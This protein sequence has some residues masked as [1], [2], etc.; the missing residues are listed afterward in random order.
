MA[1]NKS[2][3]ELM[4]LQGGT[5]ATGTAGTTG[6]QTSNQMLELIMSRKPGQY[7][8]ATDPAAQAARKQAARN[9]RTVTR[10][11]L[12]QHAAMTGGMP[13]TAAVSAAAQAGNQA[14]AAG[15]DKVAELEQMYLNNYNQETQGMYSALAALQQQEGDAFSRQMQQEQ[16]QYQKEQ[17]QKA[18]EEAEYQKKLAMAQLAASYG[19]YSGLKE[20][21]ID[22]SKYKS[23]GGSGGGGYYY[24][25]GKDGDPYQGE[26]TPK[27]PEGLSAAA[28]NELTIL[29]YDNGGYI[30]ADV[31][32]SY[33]AQYGEAAL[34]AAGFK[35]KQSNPGS[36]SSSSSGSQNPNRGGSHEGIKKG[37]SELRTGD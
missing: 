12:G 28:K 36:G 34:I 17:D 26:P 10:D 32:A 22:T 30:P 11:T 3:K 21:G 2:Y 7:N 29:A 24:T 27:E 33:A 4:E 5:G 9:A 13:S 31:W 14:M 23:S 35:K 18:Q 8:A 20:L 16:W 37:E 6:G 25:P 19:D 15:A 1:Q